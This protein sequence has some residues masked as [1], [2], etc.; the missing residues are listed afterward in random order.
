MTKY[1]KATWEKFFEPD[2]DKHPKLCQE[3]REMFKSCVKK[4]HCF[5]TTE[6]FKKCAQEDIN[7]ECI[8]YRVDFFRCKRF[9]IDR[10]KDFR[11]DPRHEI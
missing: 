5:E 4:S 9:M 6:D 1:V 8:P 11:R 3:S 7:S 2:H 10:S